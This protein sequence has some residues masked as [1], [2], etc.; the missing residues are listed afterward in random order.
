M[1]TQALRIENLKAEIKAIAEQHRQDRIAAKFARTWV[2]ASKR[3]PIRGPM[4]GAIRVIAWHDESMEPCWF[5][6]ETG[7]WYSY[8][9][10]WCQ[11]PQDE[12]T[13]VTHWMGTDW[14]H[15]REWPL[16]GPGI[17]NRM[18]YLW[19]RFTQGAS[20]MAHAN[21][22]KAW[23]YKAQLDR[24][25]VFYRDRSGRLMTGLPENVP[26]P[27]GYEKITCGSALEAERYSAMQRQQERV[28]HGFEM[29]RR[30]AIEGSF[31]NEIRSEIHT[32]MANARNN[33]NREFLRRALERNDGRHA[34]WKYER[35]SYLHAEGHEQ[36]H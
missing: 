22:P 9:G 29:E 7:K 26:S 31:Q 36:G 20:D 6:E 10:T 1:S 18:R 25:P 8:N 24:K 3:L 27:R 19:R 17:M 30:G 23:G 33:V 35:E 34:P 12:I 16:Y 32:K 15:S 13:G 14:M 28:E 4:Q 2:T 21:L 5:A 11:W